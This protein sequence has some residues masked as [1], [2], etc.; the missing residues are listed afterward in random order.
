MDIFALILAASLFVLAIIVALGVGI[1]TIYEMR[2]GQR[3]PQTGKAFTITAGPVSNLAKVPLGAHAESARLYAQPVMSRAE[4]RF[5][6]FLRCVLHDQYLI[7][8]KMPLS[9]VVARVGW[10]E[11]GLYTMHKWGHVDFLVLD[12][13]TKS[14]LLAI[15]LD[16]ARHRLP[17]RQERDRRKNELLS[18]AN[19]KMLRFR[20]GKLWGEEEREAILTALSQHST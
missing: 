15:E 18:R 12:P 7:E 1:Y 3:T 17:E 4:S 19:I 14:P 10:L 11:N 6:D 9:D 2:K 16:D 20:T 13:R 5:H 8:S